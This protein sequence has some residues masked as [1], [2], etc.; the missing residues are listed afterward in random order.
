[1]LWVWTAPH[2]AYRLLLALFLKTSSSLH[3]LYKEPK[4]AKSWSQVLNSSFAL[5][6]LAV[7]KSRCLQQQCFTD[8]Q[9]LRSVKQLFLFLNVK[10][11]N[12]KGERGH[13][14]Q[15]TKQQPSATSTSTATQPHPTGNSELQPLWWSCHL[16]THLFPFPLSYFNRLQW[17]MK[18]D[19]WW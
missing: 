7:F 15:H 5:L 4:W 19:R 10:K 12:K 6:Q 18:D 2:F 9:A 17:I 14:V 11:K 13:V 3:E 8:P 16:G 1:M